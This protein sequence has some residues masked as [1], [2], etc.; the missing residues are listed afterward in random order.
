MA[1]VIPTTTEEGEH[2]LPDGVELYTKTWKPSTPPVA[3]VVFIHGFSDHIN[4]YNTLF[5]T[6]A[7]RRIQ[8]CGF[9]Q[10][11]WG[12]SVTS[13]ASRGLTG[14]TSMVLADMTS[15]LRVQLER[16]RENVPVFL[17]GHSMGGA[18]VLQYAAR[19][20]IEVRRQLRGYLAEAP[21]IA[22]HQDSQPARLT[23]VAGRLVAKLLPRRQMV[24]KINPEA[25]SRDPEICRQYDADEL[26]HDTAS[27][28]GL[29]GM[30]QRGKELERGEIMIADREGMSIWAGHGTEDRVCSFEATKRLVERMNVKD[31]EF[32]I[33]DGWY[34]KLH[35][36][37]GEDKAIF[38]NEVADWILKR[39]GRYE[40]QTRDVIQG[41]SKL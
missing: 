15:F 3:L 19:G 33:Y 31:K 6:L 11:G 28:E 24:Q 2:I 23:V 16:N 12:R 5:P 27:L 41:R 21:F 7:S 18:Q 17:M 32:R 37:P 14:P 35:A 10:R 36:E 22:L 13:P 8:I 9:D 20:P 30:L 40:G 34:H 4:A 25:M 26:C 38:A 1:I 29:A 39:A